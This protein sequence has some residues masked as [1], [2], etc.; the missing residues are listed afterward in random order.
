MFNSTTIQKKVGIELRLL[1]EIRRAVS[2]GNNVGEDISSQAPV[3]RHEMAG[4]F[5][6]KSHLGFTV[7]DTRRWCVLFFCQVNR[8]LKYIFGGCSARGT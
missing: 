1:Y 3:G 8:E 2:T 6:R 4:R 7:S 5:G